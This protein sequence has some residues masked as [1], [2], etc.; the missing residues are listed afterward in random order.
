MRDQEIRRWVAALAAALGEP[1]KTAAPALPAAS[2]FQQC[3][4]T[5]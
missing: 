1:R 3:T 2:P 5:L 4:G